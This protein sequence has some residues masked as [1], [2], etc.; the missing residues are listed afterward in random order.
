M[1][2]RITSAYKT[3]GAYDVKKISSPAQKNRAGIA[4]NTDSVSFSAAAHDLSLAR[5]AVNEIPDVREAE[6]NRL[7]PAVSDGSYYVSGAMVAARIFG[8]V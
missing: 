1:D 6:V 8:T 3:Y 7:A 5:K 4:V 2:V